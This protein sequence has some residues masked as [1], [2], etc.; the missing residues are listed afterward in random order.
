MNS[1]DMKVFFLADDLGFIDIGAN[2]P[3]TF[4]ETPNIDRLPSTGMRSTEG[5]SSCRVCSPSRASLMTG[6]YP[7]RTGVTDYIS[8]GRYT[9]GKLAAAPNHDHIAL[10]EITIAERLRAT[11]YATFL[12]G[13]WHLGDGAFSANAQEAVMPTPNLRSTR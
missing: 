2:N 11:G 5:Y 12:A 9:Q 7:P 8:G 13:K 4:Y 10:E 6:K 3:Q 1:D